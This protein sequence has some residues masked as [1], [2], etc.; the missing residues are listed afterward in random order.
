VKAEEL[1]RH[2]VKRIAIDKKDGIG[3][4]NGRDITVHTIVL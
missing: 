2:Q 3:R 1:T 4:V